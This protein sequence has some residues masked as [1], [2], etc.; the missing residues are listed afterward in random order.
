MIQ[1]VSSLSVING[2]TVRLS[3]GDYSQE[4][5]YKESPLDIAKKFEEYGIR[6]IHLVDLEGAKKG[7]I[8]N[9]HILETIAGHTNLKINFSGGIHTDGDISQA[10]EYGAESITA[11]TMA[12]Y[13]SDLFVSGLQSYGR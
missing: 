1:L 3:K 7:S 2:K 5:E 9:Y 8:V 4:K 13:D 6:R 12:V 10:F 11:A